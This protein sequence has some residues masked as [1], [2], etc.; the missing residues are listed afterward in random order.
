MFA[1]EELALK[2][3][4]SEARVQVWFQNRRAKWRKR[5]PPRKTGYI[6]PNSPSVN[7]GNSLGPPFATFQQSNTVSPPTDTWTS[8]PAPYEIGS[9]Y[10]LLSPTG[11]P[12]ATS[13]SS[14]YSPYVH[15]SSLFSA[16]HQY[17]YGSPP[18]PSGHLSV[19]GG[20]LDDK[21]NHSTGGN[22]GDHYAHLDDKYDNNCGGSDG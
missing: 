16:R 20:E 2:L 5:E 1:R 12:Y 17:E 3:N 7:M 19:A 15:E 10:S 18:R 13:Y 4:L 14:Q 21:M 9:Q 11:S 8:Y 22:S 6:G